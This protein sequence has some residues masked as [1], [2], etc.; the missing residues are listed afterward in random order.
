[1]SAASKLDQA[2]SKLD[3]AVID[4]QTHEPV[5]TLLRA[6]TVT[7][8]PIKWLWD[9]WLAQGKLHLYAGP[10]G[11]GKTTVCLGIAATISS[12]GTFPDGSVCKPMNVVIWSG[13]DGIE[14]ILVPRLIKA[15]ANLNRVHF[16]ESVTT[17]RGKRCF[18]PSKDLP[19]LSAK[20]EKMDDVGLL[21]VD[22]VADTITG[23]G[24]SNNQVRRALAPLVEL[25]T[26][27]NCATVGIGHFNKKIGAGAIHRILDSAA[28]V[29]VPRLVWV[30][31]QEKDN[32]C[33]LLRAK[34]NIGPNGDGF[35]YNIHKGNLANY[36]DISA[37]SALWG[38][39]VTGTA[40]EWL[41]RAELPDGEDEKHTMLERAKDWL[42]GLMREHGPM[43]QADIER[44]A[45]EQNISSATLRRAKKALNLSSSFKDRTWYWGYE[46]D[47]FPKT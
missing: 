35:R 36:P 39:A 44:L 6:S 25:S 28:F 41:E 30:S 47:L 15:G 21:S 18:D 43:R 13:E 38:E 45:V 46:E 37:T 1:M 17:K 11:V 4:K 16:V 20:L 8:K 12:G 7:P 22:S 42:D 24:A 19:H 5:V 27:I 10:G 9:G 23:D 33:L 34:S 3:Q 31:F 2:V 32:G 40:D 29:N 14:D 26:R